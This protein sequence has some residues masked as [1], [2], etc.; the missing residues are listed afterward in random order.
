MINVRLEPA[1]ARLRLEVVFDAPSVP[2]Q[3]MERAFAPFASVEYEAAA[4]S[5]VQSDC[6]CAAR[7][8]ASMAESACDEPHGRPADVDP[9]SP[10]M[11]H[12]MSDA[13]VLIIDDDADLRDLYGWLLN[14]RTSMWWRPPRASK[15]S[16]RSEQIASRSASSCSTTSCRAWIRH[17]ARGCAALAGSTA[18]VLCTA[19]VNPAARAA[20]KSGSHAS[21]P[22]PSSWMRWRPWCAKRRSNMSRRGSG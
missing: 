2:A 6:F 20:L 4:E 1:A 22:S 21:W 17:A 12:A 7:S 18:I 11:S 15:E 3:E 16:P 8:L 14:R 13:A 5:G 9:R 19:G 10:C